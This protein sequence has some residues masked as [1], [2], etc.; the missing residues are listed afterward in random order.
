MTE[1]KLGLDKM[2]AGIHL[3]L[4]LGYLCGVA[5]LSAG[6]LKEPGPG[7]FPA[8]IGGLWAL[9]SLFTLIR[10]SQTRGETLEKAVVLRLLKVSAAI[11]VYFIFIPLTGFSVS[12]FLVLL[13]ASRLLGNNDWLRN[14]G[15][16]LLGV[17]FSVLIFQ[18]VLQL[19]LPEPFLEMLDL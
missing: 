2:I 8:I 6:S 18:V 12:T 5:S 7:M 3:L 1:R 19:P 15:F 14:T 17:V 4:A 10:N 11:V 13:V 16:S 9:L